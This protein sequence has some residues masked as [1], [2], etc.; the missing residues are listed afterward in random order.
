MALLGVARPQKGA[1]PHPRTDAS[2]A[3]VFLGT[4]W[5]FCAA[6]ARTPQSR[7]VI[8]LAYS[9]GGDRR[10]PCVRETNSP[11]SWRRKARNLN[12]RIRGRRPHWPAA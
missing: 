7:L 1:E 12:A 3:F 6:T 11:N 8:R 5:A 4:C 2:K 10:E 9:Q